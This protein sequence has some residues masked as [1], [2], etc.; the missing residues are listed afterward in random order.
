MKEEERIE[1]VGVAVEDFMYVCTCNLDAK[2]CDFVNGVGRNWSQAPL[3]RLE[4]IGD[5]YGGCPRGSDEFRNL[6][7]RKTEPSGGGVFISD[8]Y[9]SKDQ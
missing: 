4:T 6:M 8:A 7:M 1:A 5:S 2:S 9:I 3:C